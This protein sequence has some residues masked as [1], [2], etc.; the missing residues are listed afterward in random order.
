MVWKWNNSFLKPITYDRVKQ[1][2]KTFA[3]AD[4]GNFGYRTS[5]LKKTSRNEINPHT[6]KIFRYTGRYIVLKLNFNFFIPIRVF[7]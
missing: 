2:R 4:F 7:P 1:S 5:I 6:N 3:A